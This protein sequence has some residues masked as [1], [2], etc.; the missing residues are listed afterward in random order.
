MVFVGVIIQYV[1]TVL[2]FLLE[3]TNLINVVFAIV[4]HQM[5]AS[6]IALECMADLPM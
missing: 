4:I 5:I 2:A 3:I 1:Q 6:R